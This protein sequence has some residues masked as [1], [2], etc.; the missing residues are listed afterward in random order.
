[1]RRHMSFNQ[2]PADSTTERRSEIREDLS[3]FAATPHVVVLS[4][5]DAFRAEL[6]NQCGDGIGIRV[7]SVEPATHIGQPLDV[8]YHGSRRSAV[9]RH[10]TET[11]EGAVIGLRWRPE[12]V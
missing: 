3:Q 11:E 5:T 4:A 7:S 12:E 2:P 10:I 6:S 1:M 9:I 8:I